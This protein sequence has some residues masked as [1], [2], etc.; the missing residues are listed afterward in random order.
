[1]CIQKQM[2][3][4]V[5]EQA[6]KIQAEKIRL[7]N[8][9]IK[10]KTGLEIDVVKEFKKRFPIIKAEYNSY[11]QQESWFYNDGSDLGLE[12]IVFYNDTIDNVNLLDLGKDFKFKTTIKYK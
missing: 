2:S 8:L 5:N 12:L 11:N 3:D 7:V 1:M 10:E 4:I 6:E 9:R